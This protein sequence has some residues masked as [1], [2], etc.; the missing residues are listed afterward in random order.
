MDFDVGIK[1]GSLLGGLGPPEKI[2]MFSSL[3]DA[4]ELADARFP[5]TINGLKKREFKTE[6]VVLVVGEL[7]EI[8][9][10]LLSSSER[11]NID[12]KSI[13]TSNGKFI[14]DVLLEYLNFAHEEGVGASI[15]FCPRRTTVA[16][17]G[18]VTIVFDSSK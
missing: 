11:G 15:E 7:Q 5:A 9:R 17:P 3:I 6:D 12:V 14:A 16:P 10:E 4:L 8:K 1:V 13:Q 2:D 18:S